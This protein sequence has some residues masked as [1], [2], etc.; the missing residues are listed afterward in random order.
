MLL[1]RR[2]LHRRLIEVMV[3]FDSASE[4]ESLDWSEDS[5]SVVSSSEE[6][7]NEEEEEEDEEDV[8]ESS[9]DASKVERLACVEMA[10][11]RGVLIFRFLISLRW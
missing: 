5:E 8:S 11:I 6:E 9:L 7:E 10:L 4:E 3:E 1:G 2:P